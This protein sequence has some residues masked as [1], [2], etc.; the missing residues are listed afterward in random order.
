MLGPPTP[1]RTTRGRH[2]IRAR[3]AAARRHVAARSRP[4]TRAA[5]RPAPGCCSASRRR[6]RCTRHRFD[7]AGRRHARAAGGRSAR[8]RGRPPASASAGRH[9]ARRSPVHTGE[10]GHWFTQPA[11]FTVVPSCV[12][13]STGAPRLS[14]L[15][16]SACRCLLPR[17]YSCAA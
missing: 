11:L 1:R 8:R 13:P 10:R 9:G 7:G 15:R 4:Q 14:S 2:A 16:S 3:L 17:T 12:G 5:S 6:P